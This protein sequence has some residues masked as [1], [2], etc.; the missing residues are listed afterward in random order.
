M[1]DGGLDDLM[2]NPAFLEVGDSSSDENGSPPKPPV[3]IDDEGDIIMDEE[4][5]LVPMTAGKSILFGSEMYDEPIPL[6]KI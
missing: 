1:P 6:K 2:M 4:V 3:E 5:E